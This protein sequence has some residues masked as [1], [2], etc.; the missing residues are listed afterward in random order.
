M[1]D[2]VYFSNHVVSC[3]D[4]SYE[5]MLQFNDLAMKASHNIYDKYS[6]EDTE[7]IIRN[8]FNNILGIDYATASRTQRRQAW[9]AHDKEVF[10]VIENIL[11]DKMVSGWDESN[12][13]FLDLVDDRNIARGDTNHF[14][15]N[16]EGYF[17]VSVWSGNHHD[18]VR[19]KVLPGKAYALDTKGYVVKTYTDW[20]SFMLGKVDWPGMIDLMYRSIEKYRLSALYTAFLSLENYVPADL[21]ASIAIAE[22]TKDSII[23][24]IEAV[25]ATTGKDVML[26]GTRVAL[27][28]LQN[29]VP[30][31]MWSPE[32]KNEK[33]STPGGILAMW[34][35][36]RCVTLDRVNIQGTRDSVFTANDNKK[37][38]IIPID[39]EFKP[40]KRVNE[41]DV[42]VASRGEDGLFYQDKTMDTEIWYYEGIGVVVDELFGVIID[43][44]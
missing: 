33:H 7:K 10:S 21:K 35:G 38:F 30:Y 26:V 27:Q 8:Q 41:G 40:I 22:A 19:Q 17:Q 37:I 4:N 31:Q 9:R 3:F 44:S 23:E 42:E 5:N 14:Y 24:K 28:K 43:N 25:R 20:E 11:I 32:M 36:Y 6:K 16:S 13:P 1:K 12:A 18:I 39:P 15:V 2:I 29:T 34:E